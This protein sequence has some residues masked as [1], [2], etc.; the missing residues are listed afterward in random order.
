M[1]RV[2]RLANNATGTEYAHY[3]AQSWRR[4]P[5]TPNAL[6]AGQGGNYLGQQ[7]AYI[8]TRQQPLAS[9]ATLVAMT[10]AQSVWLPLSRLQQCPQPPGCQP[11]QPPAC[12]A[13]PTCEV[14]RV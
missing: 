10:A 14:H 11:A 5:A 1:S 6:C 4:C 3:S 2:T 8:G 13:E 9:A 12:C 7:A